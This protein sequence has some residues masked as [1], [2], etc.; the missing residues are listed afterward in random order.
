MF[1]VMTICAFA[2]LKEKSID[3]FRFVAISVTFVIFVVQPLFYLSGDAKFRDIASQKGLMQAL[4]IEL[5]QINR[6]GQAPL[7]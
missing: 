5:L 7:E 4:K 1:L 2:G 3:L 6:I